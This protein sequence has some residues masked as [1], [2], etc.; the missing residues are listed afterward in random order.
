MSERTWTLIGADGRP[1][2]SAV[3]GTLGGHRRQKT[4]GLLDCPAA[5]RAIARGGYL[6]HRVFF[7]DEAAARAAGYRPCA[8]CMP[9]AHARWKRTRGASASRR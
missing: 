1:Y 9:Q 3:P 7:L 2:A 6:R 8:A 5:L 4:Y